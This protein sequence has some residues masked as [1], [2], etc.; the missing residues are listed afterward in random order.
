[1]TKYIYEIETIA[2]SI[3]TGRSN[4][5][6]LEIIN[7]RGELGWRFVGFAPSYSRPKGVKGLELVFEKEI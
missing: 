2:F 5:D 3:W 6:Y 7:S 1:M 4:N